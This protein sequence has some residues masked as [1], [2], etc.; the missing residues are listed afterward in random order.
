MQAAVSG[1]DLVERRF[2]VNNDSIEKGGSIDSIM[3]PAHDNH[4][5]NVYANK[6]GK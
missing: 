5:Q 6:H 2:S 3:S 1:Q 4:F